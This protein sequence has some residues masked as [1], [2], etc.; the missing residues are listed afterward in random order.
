M[1]EPE[2]NVLGGVLQPCGTEPLTGFYRDGVCSTGPED[3]GSHTVCTVVSQEFLAVQRELGN[4]LTTPRPEYGFPGLRPGDRWCVVAARWLQAYRAG[5]AAGVVLAATNARALDVVP[6]A[7]LR[8]HA[9]D[10]PDDVSSL[11]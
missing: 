11:E 9:V 4:D 7:A 3:L 2:R 10:V 6:L 5:A 1:T 8:Q